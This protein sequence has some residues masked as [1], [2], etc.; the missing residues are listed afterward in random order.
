MPTSSSA[1]CTSFLSPQAQRLSL[2]FPTTVF[3]TSGF[4][5]AKIRSSISIA[6]IRHC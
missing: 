6:L 1:T 2:S 3:A 5:T 4:Q